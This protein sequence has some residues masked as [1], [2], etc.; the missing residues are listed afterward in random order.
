MNLSLRL[1][2]LA[3]AGGTAIAPAFAVDLPPRKPGLWLMTMTMSGGGGQ[4]LREMRLCVDSSTEAAMLAVGGN[5]LKDACSKNEVKRDGFMVTTS[6]V[7]DMGS[8]RMTSRGTTRFDGDTAYHSEIQT[9]YDPPFMGRAV[10]DMTQDAKW[11]GPCPA[12]MQPGDVVMP[13][14]MK[15]NFKTM[16]P[17]QGRN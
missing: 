14:G 15:M 13:N 11:I 8:T 6:A 3:V 9:K 2:V 16:M 7:C 5:M 4:P 17:G 1:A 10:S 12:D